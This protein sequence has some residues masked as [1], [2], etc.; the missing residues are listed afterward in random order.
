MSD[1]HS[2]SKAKITSLFGNTFLILV[3]ITLI[4]MLGIVGASFI[5]GMK[6][7]PAKA[8]EVTA[9]VPA[10]ATGAAAAT[11]PAPAAGTPVAATA[12]APAASG[13][14]VDPA[15]MALGKTTYMMC[16]ACHGPDA[17]GLQAGP[18]LMAPSLVGSEM[19]LGDPDKPLLVVLK[20][21]AKENMDF[22][23]MM[24]PLGAALDD[25]KLAAVLT[26]L[27][28]DHGNSAPAVTVEQVAAARTKFADVNAPAGVKR[29]EIDQI[30]AAHK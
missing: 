14:G 1:D 26:Y 28:N 12:P 10:P 7:K 16:G 25:E 4:A 23:G 22:M 9:T 15:V 6:R 13:A 5:G 20:G 27:R 29:A 24:A 21:I 17:K 3:P 18:A 11:S 8:A 30:V 2:D 19:L